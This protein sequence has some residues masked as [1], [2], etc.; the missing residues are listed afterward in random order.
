MP[1]AKRPAIAYSGP[2]PPAEAVDRL[3]APARG[4]GRAFWSDLIREGSEGPERRF[5]GPRDGLGRA[6]LTILRFVPTSAQSQGASG[7]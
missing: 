4:E 6:A 3:P 2:P 1:T 7:R 5:A